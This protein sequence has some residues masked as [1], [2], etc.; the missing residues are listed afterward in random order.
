[1]SFFC[2]EPEGLGLVFCGVP[3]YNPAVFGGCTKAGS[4]DL[5][6]SGCF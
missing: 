5:Q 3:G 6:P 1:M 4:G 2:P